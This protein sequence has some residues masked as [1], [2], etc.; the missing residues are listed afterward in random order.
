MSMATSAAAQGGYCA[1]RGGLG[2]TA[3]TISEAR[4]SVEMGVIDWEQ[5]KT[6]GVRTDAISVGDLLVRYGV[7]DAFEAQIGCTAFSSR[8]SGGKRESGVGDVGLAVRHMVYEGPVAVAVMPFVSLPAG[9]NGFGAGDWGAGLQ[10]PVEAELPGNLGLGLTGTVEAAVDADRDG[11]HLA[12][13]GVI[14]LGLPV[15][16]RFAAL[17]ELAAWRDL[18]PDGASTAWLAGLSGTWLATDDLQLDV[19]ADLGLDRGSPDVALH[20]GFARRF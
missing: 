5:D 9:S 19:G 3:C 20:L 18:D 10:V 12:Y 15:P 4:L 6:A 1:D 8:S 2:G 16:E 11:R 17:V 7:S 14:G 13:G